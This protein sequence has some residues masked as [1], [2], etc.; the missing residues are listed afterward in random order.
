MMGIKNRT[1]SSRKV[2]D[3]LVLVLALALVL[4]L[5]LL[6]LLHATSC[7]HF[8]YRGRRIRRALGIYLDL[9]CSPNLGD[10]CG[11]QL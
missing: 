7:R 10:V 4:L 1:S 3:Q 2:D 6:L 5:L 9:F 11:V 8:P